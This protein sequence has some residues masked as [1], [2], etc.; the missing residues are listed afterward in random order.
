MTIVESLTLPQGFVVAY[1]YSQLETKVRSDG[2]DGSAAVAQLAAKTKSCER[3]RDRLSTEERQETESEEPSC[4]ALAASILFDNDQLTPECEALGVAVF[5]AEGKLLTHREVDER[6]MA[7]VDH[8]GLH[9][10]SPHEAP[11][12][13]LVATFVVAGNLHDGGWG[14]N[15]KSSDL[16]I[17][18][19]NAEND[20]SPLRPL[21]TI[22]MDEEFD[23][24]DCPYGRRRVLVT[25]HDHSLELYEQGWNDCAKRAYPVDRLR[26]E[27]NADEHAW[28]EPDYDE[29][30]GTALPAGVLE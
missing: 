6:C 29:W 17:Y 3:E 26:T 7:S 11:D 15:E 22:E 21:T 9:D 5:D 13:A 23:N 19:P 30:E 4:E 16:H 10:L 28:P 8:F 2:S 1:R 20:E 18:A 24:G 27:W 25:G 14:P 12:L